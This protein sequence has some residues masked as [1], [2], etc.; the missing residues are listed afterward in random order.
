[1]EILA[2][3]GDWTHTD[4]LALAAFLET[5]TGRRL[6]PALVSTS[7]GLL[8]GGDINAILIRSG[9]VMAFQKVLETILTLAHPPA[10]VL[11]PAN[12]Y[13]ALEDDTAWNDG[14]TLE[15]PKPETQ[16]TQTPS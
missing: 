3:V 13:P 6:I 11:E 2:N 15:V 10:R 12:A 8:A 4:E 7:P 5:A 16:T 14:Q 1:M 9:E